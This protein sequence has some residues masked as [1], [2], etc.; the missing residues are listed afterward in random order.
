MIGSLH[1][2]IWRW[3]ALGLGHP[4]RSAERS[5]ESMRGLRAMI[6]AIK[7]RNADLAEKIIRA[8]VTEA[9]AEVTR[10]L[11]GRGLPVTVRPNPRA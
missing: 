11:A 2:R 7:A 4:Q 8:E 1:G 6:T 5:L 9:A 10:L 3:R